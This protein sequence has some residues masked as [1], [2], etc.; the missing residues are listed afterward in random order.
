MIT[1]IMYFHAMDNFSG[2]IS[3]AM[4]QSVNINIVRCDLEQIQKYVDLRILI[5][6]DEF[7]RIIRNYNEIANE[8]K[9]FET[10][11]ILEFQKIINICQEKNTILKK[12]RFIENLYSK[13]YE[14][15]KI[16]KMETVPADIY[17]KIDHDIKFLEIQIEI[18]LLENKLIMMEI[19]SLNNKNMENKIIMK[20]YLDSKV[21]SLINY[22]NDIKLKY[23][24][25]REVLMNL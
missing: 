6:D 2:K 15:D 1:G 25:K 21:N 14:I 19:N 11:E 4:K 24:S 7:E 18:V 10:Q 16:L 8:K 3:C 12:V 17:E 13:C 20:Y 9:E 22:H 5:P 23:D